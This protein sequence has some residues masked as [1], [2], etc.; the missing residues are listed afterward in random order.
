MTRKATMLK[1]VTVFIAVFGF[2]L[3]VGSPAQA[4]EKEE[5]HKPITQKGSAALMFSIDGLGTFNVQAP[6]MIAVPVPFLGNFPAGDSLMMLPGLGAK[7]FIADDL[8][9][10]VMLGF[11][12]TSAKATDTTETPSTRNT[13]ASSTAW[14]VG[15]GAEMHF[16]PLYSVTPY[17]GI[18]V[19]YVSSSTDEPTNAD[20]TYSGHNLGVQLFFGF[21]WF[22]TRGIAVGA[23]G[24]LGWQSWALDQKYS[25][26]TG[27][28]TEVNGPVGSSIALAM[29]GLVHVVVYF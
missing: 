21:D 4:Q 16:R 2:A 18:Q 20:I 11:N 25:P 24:G 1:A 14:G 28:S 26:K 15:A 13:L 27:S 19:M 8:A 12:H 23:E 29:N 7:F 6:G 10:R 5:W 3:A 9:L 17:G 22:V